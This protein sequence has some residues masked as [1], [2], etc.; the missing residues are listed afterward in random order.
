MLSLDSS[1]KMRSDWLWLG[2]V[3][4]LDSS[5]KMRSDWLWLGHVPIVEPVAVPRPLYLATLGPHRHQ[6]GCTQSVARRERK[7]GVVV[8][9]EKLMFFYQQISAVEIHTHPF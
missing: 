9:Q 8:L 2:H 7:Q 3:L 6:E 5:P 4:T 1:P